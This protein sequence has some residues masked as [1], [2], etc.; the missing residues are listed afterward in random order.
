MV[1][2]FT[3]V[4][5]IPIR[6]FQFAFYFIVGITLSSFVFVICDRS[7]MQPFVGV[8]AYAVT[9]Y[10][11]LNYQFSPQTLSLAFLMGIFLVEF[12][13]RKSKSIIIALF[14][15]AA[16]LTHGFL[17]LFYLVYLMVRYVWTRDGLEKIVSYIAIFATFN[18]FFSDFSLPRLVLTLR[19][20]IIE[21]LGI[22]QYRET[23]EVTASAGS[24]VIIQQFSRAT[25]VGAGLISLFGVIRGWKHE[26]SDFDKFL[27]ATAIV[28][29]VVGAA[30]WL[31]G[32]RAVQ[33]GVAVVAVGASIFSGKPKPR[34]RRLLVFALILLSVS[35]PMHTNFDRY[36]YQSQPTEDAFGFLAGRI[37]DATQVRRVNIFVPH[38]VAFSV[39]VYAKNWDNLGLQ[40]ELS[41]DDAMGNFDL[42]LVS[43]QVDHYLAARKASYPPNVIVVMTSGNIIYNDGLARIVSRP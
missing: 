3:L 37:I 31:I 11:F 28:L 13:L 17:Q 14:F 8:W 39:L 1:N 27:M 21:S 36:L 24:D 23:I 18:F 33:V 4:T 15:V 22:L 5:G 26:L 41:T 6:L 20:S 30:V 42:V 2:T 7:I 19:Q 16:T 29:V 34:W 38:A 32:I 35:I 12:K 40:T 25:I 9:G 43:L 10:Y